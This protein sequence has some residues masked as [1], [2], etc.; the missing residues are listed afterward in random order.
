MQRRASEI[1]NEIARIRSDPNMDTDLKDKRINRLTQ[2]R[3]AMLRAVVEST[4]VEI[5]Y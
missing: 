2:L 5:R 3:N 4:P 1:T